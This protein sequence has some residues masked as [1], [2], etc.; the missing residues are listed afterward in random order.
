MM[1][2]ALARTALLSFGRYSEQIEVVGALTLVLQTKLPHKKML[3]VTGVMIAGVLVTMVGSTVHT[4]QLI[5]WVPIS[6]IPRPEGLPCW[7]GIW[8]RVH[9]TWQGIV[10][11]LAAIVFV[12]GSYFLAERQHERARI[13]MATV[14]PATRRGGAVTA[15]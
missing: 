12:F 15:S 1:R 13:G 10:A 2:C 14:T 5:G 9:G 3:I 8:L 11:Q 4:L 6:P 7:A